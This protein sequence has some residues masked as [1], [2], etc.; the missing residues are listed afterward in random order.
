MMNKDELKKFANLAKQTIKNGNN[1]S[2]LRHLLSQYLPKI[3]PDEPWWIQE[4]VMGTEMH[5]ETSKVSGEKKDGYV[6]TV[7]GKTAVEYEKNL[8]NQSIF[9][10]GFSQVKE[11]CAAFCNRGIDQNEVL[12][13]LSDTVRWYGYSITI[14]T[15]YDENRSLGAEDI[16]LKQRDFVDLSDL[17]DK[18]F[19]KFELFVNKY[20]ARNESRIPTAELLVL[21]FGMDSNFYA[22]Q[23][24]YFKDAV[25]FAMTNNRSYADLI[26][27]VWQDF[28]AYLG[29]S[30]YGSFST[31]TYVNE[32]YLVTIAKLICANILNG[33]PLICDDDEIVQILNGDYFKQKN[34]QNFVDYDY[35]GWL[36]TSPYV[37][38]I[39]DC[40]K[41]T[42]RILNSYDFQM[43]AKKDLFGA[44]LAQLSDRE[45]RLLLGQDYTPNWLARDMVKFTLREIPTE[46][47]V[48]DMCCGSGVFLIETIRTVRELYVKCL[49]DYS[50]E[51]D[52]LLFSC[53]MGFDIDPLA[54]IL[55]KVNWIMAM[56]DV[57]PY[58]KGQ[59]TI[60]I[61]HADSLFAA[62]PITHNIHS[63]NADSYVM[64]FDGGKVA[65]PSQM[66]KP[67]HR[68]FFDTFIAI[69]YKYA[70]QRAKKDEISLTDNQIENILSSIMKESG[71]ILSKSEENEQKKFAK[72]LILQL[73]NLQRQGKNGIWYFIL[74]NSYK[75]GL[76][77]NQFD[78]IV[79]NPPWLAMS[80][81]A[82]NPYTK[83]LH[84]K[85]ASLCILP[86]GSSH[87]HMELST[88][89]LLES[90]NKYL[91]KDGRWICV[92]PG[93]VVSGAHH[94]PFRKEKYRN[95]VKT[96][97]DTI[98]DIPKTTFKNRAVVLSG[99]KSDNASIYPIEG[100]IYSESKEYAECSYALITQGKRSAW[101]NQGRNSDILDIVS[102]Y[103]GLFP[104]GA[105]IMP[106]TA[107]F[108][109]F[110][111]QPNGTWKIK[112]ITEDS[113]LLYLLSDCKKDICKK[114]TATGF[115]DAYM[116]DCLISKHLSPFFISSSAKVL[117]PGKKEKGIWGELTEE[118][119]AS[120]NSGTSFVFKEI[121]RECEVSLPQ[122][123]AKINILDK[124]K[125]Q[126]FS[127]KR[128]LVLSNAGGGHP[129]AAILD[130][131]NLNIE[132]LIVD[133]TLYWYLTQSKKEAVYIAGLL[134]S[135]ALSAAISEFQ[136]QG[137][138]GARHIHTIPFKI[139][140]KFNT[141]N[142]KHENLVKI[143]ERLITEWKTIYDSE[144][145]KKFFSPSERSLASRR[146]KLRLLLQTLPSYKQYEDACY[147]VLCN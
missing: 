133:Q 69:C 77:A 18:S 45:H 72:D 29:A 135:S 19:N 137:G 31:E 10:D 142:D 145:K 108:H 89:F 104:Q 2:V 60:P 109:D 99:K 26:K 112:E 121:S 127:G 41:K 6:D 147:S 107:L 119:I 128:W 53:V 115:D 34:I 16:E 88:T 40:A 11:Y 3:F 35:F 90:I 7:I 81:M 37:E 123:F 4:H 131:N 125:N 95:V 61:Y 106:R 27:K 8:M 86:P 100:R 15:N 22:Q 79:S 126:T 129:C 114:L 64:D 24:K 1:E 84:S 143:T 55:A 57:F 132:K 124:L 56:S 47:H 23:I 21:D 73:E 144:E 39:I 9:E 44:L 130:L 92:M 98:W 75:P 51:K 58:H 76:V 140:P 67:N 82:N 5:V 122:L 102:S 97:I 134:N 48:L 20:F 14:T 110:Q 111:K 36:N 46:P 116:Y 103:S 105:D 80:K 94:D 93:S 28:V 138:F 65:L 85:M 74:N 118:D 101:S 141:N 96:N 120:M 54:I 25:N 91:K 71:F 83:E 30:D 68:R 38:K 43:M 59:I 32:F 17:S 117:I 136:P 50:D 70:M 13:I 113:S 87:L 12:G 78:C 49:A 33:V 146:T 63:N 42:Q 62:T 66:L 139:M 52:D